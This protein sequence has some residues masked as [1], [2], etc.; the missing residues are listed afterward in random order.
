MLSFLDPEVELAG[1]DLDAVREHECRP[2]WIARHEL[3]ERPRLGGVFVTP[4]RRALGLRGWEDAYEGLAGENPW[5]IFDLEKLIRMAL[6]QSGLAFELLTSAATWSRAE[7]GARAIARAAVTRDLIE[8]YHDV[9]RPLLDDEAEAS[10]WRWRSLLSGWALATRG[11]VSRNVAT[12]TELAGTAEQTPAVAARLI[13]EMLAGDALPRRPA[14]Y[15]WLE[16]SLV[17]ARMEAN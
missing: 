6:R 16:E 9:A 17:N 13:D 5:V 15:D 1:E 10:R 4:A 2:I 8:H 3:A 14:D 7:F 12:L 11:E